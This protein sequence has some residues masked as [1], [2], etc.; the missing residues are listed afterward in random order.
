MYKGNI[1]LTTK[2]Q[3]FWFAIGVLWFC[4]W[5]LAY[6]GSAFTPAGFKFDGWLMFA[7]FPIVLIWGIAKGISMVHSWIGQGK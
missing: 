1:V 6:I 5:T 3:R 4:G 2:R 7:V